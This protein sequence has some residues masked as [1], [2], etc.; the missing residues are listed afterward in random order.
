MTSDAA[1]KTVRSLGAASSFACLGDVVFA[2][3]GRLMSHAD[4]NYAL[5]TA[6]SCVACPVGWRVT[7]VD[8]YGDLLIVEV[9][10]AP[11]TVISLGP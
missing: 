11:A 8:V 3:G 10:L 1:L 9:Q 6:V 5:A 7:T 4:L 2:L